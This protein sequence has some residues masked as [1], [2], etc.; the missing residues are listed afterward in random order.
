M[1]GLFV[2]GAWAQAP[3][4]MTAAPPAVHKLNTAPELKSDSKM[5][6]EEKKA[7]HAAHKAHK[8]HKTHM[9]APMKE[10]KAAPSAMDKPAVE[11][12]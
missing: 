3:T 9:Q 6:M 2:V 10:D 1:A 7:S 4:D 8:V 11:K 12:K 5:P